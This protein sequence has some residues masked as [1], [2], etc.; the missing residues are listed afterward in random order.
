MT[1]LQVQRASAILRGLGIQNPPSASVGILVA[2]Q[3]C[4]GGPASRHN[5]LNT[6]LRLPGSV[7]INQEGV[8]Q[9]PNE[10]EGIRATV[11]T[12][13]DPRYAGIVQALRTGDPVAFLGQTSALRAWCGCDVASYVACLRDRYPGPLP[14]SAT[15]SSPIQVPTWVLALALGVPL[16]AALASD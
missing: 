14:P 3:E 5:P 12:L 15:P 8:Q 10:A 2:W 16:L 13:R 1:S 4:E 11:E 6:T 7:A 9:Y